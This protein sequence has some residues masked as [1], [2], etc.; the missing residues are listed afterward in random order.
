MATVDIPAT[1]L[2]DIEAA[3]R[4][5]LGQAEHDQ[6]ATEIGAMHAEAMKLLHTHEEVHESLLAEADAGRDVSESVAGV[7]ANLCKYVEALQ[8]AT[9]KLALPHPPTALRSSAVRN[10][11]EVTDR[12]A[13]L[14]RTMLVAWPELELPEG[15]RDTVLTVR[16]PPLAYLRAMFNLFWS[17]VR[18][19]RSETT[20]DLS[21]G[22]VLYRS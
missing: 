20:I 8:R 14:M 19:P 16:I 10:V 9:A 13:E 4:A 15:I 2:A 12:T 18:H 5:L 6:T 7:W 22:R 21:T 1:L 17:A 3:R 11:A